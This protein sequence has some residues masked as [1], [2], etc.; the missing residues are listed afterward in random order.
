MIVVLGAGGFAVIAA[1]MVLAARMPLRPGAYLVRR[2]PQGDSP[3]LTATLVPS[4]RALPGR[5]SAAST[6]RRIHVI[7]DARERSQ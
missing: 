3:V 4:P 2:S 1:V 6:A 7:T 5:P